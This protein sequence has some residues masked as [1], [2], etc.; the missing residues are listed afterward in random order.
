[1]LSFIF[2]AET[3]RAPLSWFHA[4][5]E[6][7]LPRQSTISALAA[8]WAIEKHE[9]C[10]KLVLKEANCSNRHGFAQFSGEAT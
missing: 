6:A 5:K 3:A 8:I 4:V 7:M 10:A 9:G 2:G 1:M